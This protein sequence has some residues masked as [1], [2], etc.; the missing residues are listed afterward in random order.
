MA[1]QW[2]RDIR[3]ESSSASCN[4]NFPGGDESGSPLS[5]LQG[6]GKGSGA[7]K[8]SGGA[9]GGSGGVKKSGKV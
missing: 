2:P 9:K 6:G 1:A 7:G 8:G 4:P 5:V 3:I